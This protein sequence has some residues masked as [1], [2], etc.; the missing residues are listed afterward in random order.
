MGTHFSCSKHGLVVSGHNQMF[1][2]GGEY[3]DG[4]ASKSVWRFD[5]LINVWQEMASMQ[6]PRSELGLALLDGHIYAIGGWDDNHEYL[7][8]VEEYDTIRYECR[9]INCEPSWT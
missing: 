4:S 9:L 7:D 3:P 1:M 6:T 8:T 2:A 5:P